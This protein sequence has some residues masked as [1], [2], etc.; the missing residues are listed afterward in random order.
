VNPA[1]H[2]DGC[3]L[4]AERRKEGRLSG[5][6]LILLMTTLVLWA[7]GLS[8]SAANCARAAA[9][10]AAEQR[11]SLSVI[12]PARNEEHNL[13]TARLTGAQSA[14]PNEIIVVDGRFDRFA[15]PKLARQLGAMVISIPT[16][17]RRLGCKTWA[18]HQ[19]AQAATRDLLMFLDA[20]TWFEP[21]GLAR[22]RLTMRAGRFRSTLSRREEVLRGAFPVL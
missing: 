8:V 13:P 6:M 7:A 5:P 15:P 21:E 17:A 20:D 11:L 9:A 2:A 14:K 10:W 16:A 19:G 3:P 1:R 18:C 12:I 4:W 22:I